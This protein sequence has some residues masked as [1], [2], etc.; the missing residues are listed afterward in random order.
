MDVCKNSVFPNA[1][2]GRGQREVLDEIDVRHE[3]QRQADKQQVT[4]ESMYKAL[5]EESLQVKIRAS[6][7]IALNNTAIT[8]R[9]NADKTTRNLM[10]VC[11]GNKCVITKM[12]L[13]KQ[14]V[15]AVILKQDA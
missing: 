3:Q 14:R 5:T 8:V 4:P 13:N 15:I 12:A 9:S 7:V 10:H 2:Q 11:D 1:S 6:V